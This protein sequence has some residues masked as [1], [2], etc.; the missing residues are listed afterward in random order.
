MFAEASSGFSYFC[1]SGSYLNLTI[2]M[3]KSIVVTVIA[4]LSALIVFSCVPGEKIQGTPEHK[5][6]EY[7]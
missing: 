4:V 2:T 3:N 7:D 5:P 6:A 1:V